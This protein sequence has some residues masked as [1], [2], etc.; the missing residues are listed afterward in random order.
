MEMIETLTEIQIPDC[1]QIILTNPLFQRYGFNAERARSMFSRALTDG[2]QILTIRVD[3]RVVGFVWY[4]LHG[5]WDRSGYIRL[6]AVLP[7]YQGSGIGKKL[8]D[9]AEQ[10]LSSQVQEVFLLVSDF[11]VAAQHFYQALD[12]QQVGGIPNYIVPGINELI[13]F[14]KLEDATPDR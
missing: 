6:I 3:Q 14:K 10:E 4:V 9:A 1:V 13:Y 12:Y 7:Q 2:A 8:M 11:N 5:A